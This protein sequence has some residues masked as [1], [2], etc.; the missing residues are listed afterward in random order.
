MLIGTLTQKEITQSIKKM[1]SA[2]GR[3][4]NPTIY[5]M[6]TINEKYRNGDS[7]VVDVVNNPKKFVLTDDVTATEKDFLNELGRVEA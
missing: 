7:F 4:V 2:L 1:Q 6:Q 5:S 3:E